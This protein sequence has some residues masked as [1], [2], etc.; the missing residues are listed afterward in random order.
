MAVMYCRAGPVMRAHRILAAVYINVILVCFCM[1]FYIRLKSS[2][3][4]MPHPRRNPPQKRGPRI[5]KYALVFWLDCT[6][7]CRDVVHQNTAKDSE[8]HPNLEEAQERVFFVGKAKAERRGRILKL[9][10]LR[11]FPTNTNHCVV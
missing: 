10:K 8:E 9:G 11:L 2:G 7:P 4:I 1:F 6:H 5:Q 3:V